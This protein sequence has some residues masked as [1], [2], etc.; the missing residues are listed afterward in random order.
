MVCKEWKLRI[1]R[2]SRKEM[3]VEDFQNYIAK[4]FPNPKVRKSIRETLKL[5][6]RVAFYVKILR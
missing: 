2:S 1:M 3:S 6:I 5:L 4:V